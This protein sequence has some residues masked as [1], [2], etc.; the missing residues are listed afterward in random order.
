[1]NHSSGRGDVEMEA[2]TRV[3]ATTIDVKPLPEPHT[4]YVCLGEGTDLLSPCACAWLHVHRE[5]LVNM[6]TA[7]PAMSTC[8]VCKQPFGNVST[9]TEQVRLVNRAE[10]ALM[11]GL[12]CGV[13][14]TGM[15]FLYMLNLLVVRGEDKASIALAALGVVC[16]SS[17]VASCVAARKLT[18][19]R[20]ETRTRA[21]VIG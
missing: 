21:V 13:M 20:V 12:L 7:S 3:D 4:C 15:F 5:C 18:V 9:V 8:S 16:L 14:T 19:V 10:A 2:K 11:L 17:S 6:V 1:M